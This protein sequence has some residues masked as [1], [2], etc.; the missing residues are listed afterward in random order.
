FNANHVKYSLGLLALG[1][2]IAYFVMMFRDRELAPQEHSRIQAFVWIFIGATL[3]WMIYDQAGSVLTLFTEKKV[4]RDLGFLT[5]P[6]AWFQSIN[7]A[8][9]LL[10]APLFAWMWIRMGSRQPGTPQKFSWAII[11][12]G[13]SFIIMAVAGS[14]AA[15]GL[16]SAWWIILVYLVQ[17]I[18]ELLL[19]P[20]G[21]SATTKLAP[22]R[23]ASQ[24]MGLWFLATAAGNALNIWIAPLSKQFS[25]V[26]YYGTIGGI[27]V[28]MGF[29]FW[30]GAKAIQRLMAGVH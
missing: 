15:K 16:I 30:M 26:V 19:S 9:I 25:D 1:V 14:L 23:Y 21:L 6:T 4:D 11:G 3:F 28:V 7:S 18:A 8:F 13:L 10:L 22:L 24:V 17:T 20:V 27:A 12:V 2:P 5:I 29:A